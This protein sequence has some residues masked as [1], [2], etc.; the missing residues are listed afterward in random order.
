MFQGTSHG[1]DRSRTLDGE[2]KEKPLLLHDDDDPQVKCSTG[3]AAQKQRRRPPG[4]V[5]V[6]GNRERFV[7][8]YDRLRDELLRDNSCDLTDEARRWVAQV[9]ELACIDETVIIV[10]AMRL[11]VNFSSDAWCNITV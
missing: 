2:L 7:R 11:Y 3:A 5:N 9:S 1:G 6:D 8:A 4:V 10:Y